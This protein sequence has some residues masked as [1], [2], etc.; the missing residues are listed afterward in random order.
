[1]H[2]NKSRENIWCYNHIA[3]GRGGTS[4][5]FVRGWSKSTSEFRPS[6]YLEKCDFVTHTKLLQKN[7][8]KQTNKQKTKTN[9]FGT[10]RV[11]VW[12]NFPKCTQFGKLGALVLERK[13]THWY[14]KNDEKAPPKNFEH[15]INQQWVCPP[16]PGVGHLH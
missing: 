13:P 5:N 1:M 11:L 4:L 7:N 6:L 2:I 3:L 15:T 10:N 16:P 8:N 9:K 12:P 14:T